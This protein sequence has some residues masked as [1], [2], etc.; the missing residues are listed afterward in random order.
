MKTSRKLFLATLTAPLT[1]SL[2]I[3]A[4]AQEPESEHYIEHANIILNIQPQPNSSTA[5]GYLL[6]TACSTCTPTRIEVNESTALYLN[7]TPI[8]PKSLGLKIDWQGAVFF[9]PG[10]PPVATRLMLN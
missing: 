3:F 6:A 8:P 4:S 7:G 1:L 10:T 2:T 9:T 5:V